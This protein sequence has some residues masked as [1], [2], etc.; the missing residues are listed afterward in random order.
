MAVGFLPP[1]NTRLKPRPCFEGQRRRLGDW[2]SRR[3][4]ADAGQ[5]HLGN[6]GGVVAVYPTSDNPGASMEIHDDGIGI[7]SLSGGKS[8]DLFQLADFGGD[9]MVKAGV[10]D[11]RTG[12]VFAG[13]ASSASGS[14]LFGRNG[15]S[16]GGD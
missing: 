8:G 13:P 4:A 15:A 3:L 1:K 16:G 11:R 5:Q 2:K 6:K 12:A 7:A 9:V 10:T 14:F